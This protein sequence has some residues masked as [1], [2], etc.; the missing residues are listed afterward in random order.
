VKE[1]NDSCLFIKTKKIIYF[2]KNVKTARR[3]P[4]DRRQTGG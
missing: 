4:A 3:Q 2:A 1:E